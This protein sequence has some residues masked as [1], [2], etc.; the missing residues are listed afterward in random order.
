MLAIIETQEEIKR[1]KKGRGSKNH[2][3]IQ[4]NIIVQMTLKYYG[5]Y[6]VIP[7]LS[8]EIDGKE[9]VPDLCFYK[10]F[11]INPEQDIIKMKDMPLG[12]VEILSPTQ[13]L[14]E[15]VTKSNLYFKAGIQSYWL[16]LPELE[17]IYVYSSK[18]KKRVFTIDNLLKDTNLDIELEVAKLFV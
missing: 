8:L 10:E 2:S 13:K 12:V 18:G 9:R 17:S 1:R 4:S 6:R 3:A 11:N 5:V 14:V 7:E 16:V 15:L